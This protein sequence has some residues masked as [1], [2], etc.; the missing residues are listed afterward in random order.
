MPFLGFFWEWEGMVCHPKIGPSC[1]EQI[2]GAGHGFLEQALD[3]SPANLLRPQRTLRILIAD[4]QRAE[5]NA[6]LD[7]I[8]DLATRELICRGLGPRVRDDPYLGRNAGRQ[9]H[10]GEVVR[11]YPVRLAAALG[12]RDADAPVR[13]ADLQGDGRVMGRDREYDDRR[14]E[15]DRKLG[16]LETMFARQAPDPA[17]GLSVLGRA[18]IIART[19]RSRTGV[20]SRIREEADVSGLRKSERGARREYTCSSH[21]YRFFS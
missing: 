4:I 12:E 1:W 5:N 18:D 21:K 14:R 6:R 11:P 19:A 3:R 7:R 8:A 20:V 9:R 13:R 2:T 15:A 16:G 10:A 17:L